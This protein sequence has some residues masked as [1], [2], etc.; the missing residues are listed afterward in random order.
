MDLS[1]SQ[2]HYIVNSQVWKS[3]FINRGHI[4]A[5]KITKYTSASI[6]HDQ[7]CT[8]FSLTLSKPSVFC[9]LCLW[10][11]DVLQ[12]HVLSLFHFNLHVL[13]FY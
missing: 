10:G 13:I 8:K 4:Q 7:T 11:I 9:Y 3:M 1:N 6:L 5:N 12:L 2:C